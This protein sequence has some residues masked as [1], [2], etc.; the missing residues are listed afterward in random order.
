MT[1]TPL[2]VASQ[3][4]NSRVASSAT[5]LSRLV[6]APP[7][8]IMIVIDVRYISNPVHAAS[9]TGVALTTPQGLDGYACGGALAL[10]L[11]FALAVRLFGSAED[12]TTLA[13][14]D[15]RVKTIG[16][17]LFLALNTLGFVLQS[18]LLQL[19]GARQ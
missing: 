11:A 19:S 2:N 12:G 4:G 3:S 13:M 10:T 16:E 9:P 14:G 7:T 6:M 18:Y 17:I 5:W 1:T 15:Q 8:L